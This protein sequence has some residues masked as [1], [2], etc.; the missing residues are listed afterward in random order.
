M[1]F[2]ENQ[3]L[4]FIKKPSNNIGLVLIYGPNSGLVNEYYEKAFDAVSQ[5]NDDPFNIVTLTPN[6][7]KENPSVLIDEVSSFSLLG[8]NKSIFIKDID[9]SVKLKIKDYVKKPMESSLIIVNGGDLKNSDSLV[10]EIK[11]SKTSA[12]IA[13][14]DY[15]A[16]DISQIIANKLREEGVY[17]DRDALD[18]FSNSISADRQVINS[19]I[20]KI[21]TY[22]GDNKKINIDDIKLLIGNS[23]QYDNDDL[24]YAAALGKEIEAQKI[25]SKLINEDVDPVSIVRSLNMHFQKIYSV[26]SQIENR[27]PIDAALNSLTPRII[28]FKVSDFRRQVSIWN[29]KVLQSIFELLLKAEKDCKSTNYPN[30]E[31]GSRTILQIASVAKKSANRR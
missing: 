11:K 6:S 24:C 3:F 18:L 14:Y 26:V 17:I 13:C 9:N 20:E 1:I 2:K 25:Y 28:F 29:S 7:F 19:E 12:L 8:G 10:G 21:I 16:S 22:T 5:D 23:S 30:I 31:I 15:N 4:D 27:V